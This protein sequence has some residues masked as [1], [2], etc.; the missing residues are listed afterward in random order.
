MT[1]T[2]DPL[3][4]SPMLGRRSSS[5]AS[6]IPA[7]FH[8]FPHHR[9]SVGTAIRCACQVLKIWSLNTPRR[10]RAKLGTRSKRNHQIASSTRLRLFLCARQ[11][12]E[13]PLRP[14]RGVAG[15]SAVFSVV[16]RSQCNTVCRCSF[17]NRRIVVLVV[18]RTVISRVCQILRRLVLMFLLVRVVFMSRL[19][20][21]TSGERPKTLAN[22]GE[23]RL[24]HEQCQAGSRS[25]LSG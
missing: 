10:L 3:I 25:G 17:V 4:K 21:A 14:P 5:N 24:R 22:S 9:K 13:C 12:K 2:Y 23:A 6:L 20:A 1:R 19:V 8:V 18:T 11:A 7:S 16:A 15:V